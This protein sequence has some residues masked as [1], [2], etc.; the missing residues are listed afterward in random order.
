MC[1]RERKA[2]S[3]GF[4]LLRRARAK[5][6]PAR[7]ERWSPTGFLVIFLQRGRDKRRS[8]A[9]WCASGT[10]WYAKANDEREMM[11]DELE[12]RVSFTSAFIIHHSAFAFLLSALELKSSLDGR[13]WPLSLYGC[14]DG[15]W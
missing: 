4:R 9:R 11:N 8:Y 1:A 7:S 2:I 14:L 5:P 10:I 6:V 3:E 15:G 12:S 13:D